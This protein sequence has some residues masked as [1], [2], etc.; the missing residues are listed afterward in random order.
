MGNINDES[1][2]GNLTQVG[3]NKPDERDGLSLGDQSTFGALAGHDDTILESEIEI[4][5]LTSRYTIE[6]PLGKGGMGEVLLANDNRL[7]RKVAIKRVLTEKSRSQIAVSRF[8]TEAQ[9]IASLNHFNIVQVYDYGRDKHGP[10]LIMEYVDGTNLLD[11]CR[12]GAIPLEAAIQITCQLCD[13]LGRAHELGIIHRDIKPANILLTKDGKPK[14]TD[15]GLAKAE[16]TDNGMTIAGA[17]LGTLDFMPPEQRS[18]AALTDARSDLW[19]LAATFYQMVTGKSPRV[20]RLHEFPK[21]LQ[22]VLSKA[23]EDRKEDRYQSAAEFQDALESYTRLAPEAP[24][25]G[26]DL[27]TGEC[28]SCRTKNESHRKF[29]RE[30]AASLRV[31]CLSCK[32]ELPV[33]DKV[34]PE[35]GKKQAELVAARVAAM[36]LERKKA[37]ELYN[38]YAFD[39]AIR[40]VQS[41]GSETDSRLQQLKSWADTFALELTE[42]R[43]RQEDSASKQYADAK[44]HRQ[45]FDYQS[46]IHALESIP[47][48]MRTDEMLQFLV[49]LHEDHET[50]SRLMKEIANRLKRKEMDGL[51]ELIDRAIVLRGEDQELL[52]LKG[53]L[54]KSAASCDDAQQLLNKGKA[55]EALGLIL[56]LEEVYL[57]S[58]QQALKSKLRS[59]VDAELEMTAAVKEANAGG[60]DPDKVVVLL[61]LV[62]AYLQINPHHEKAGSLFQQLIDRVNKT[63]LAYQELFRKLP[64]GVL[65]SIPIESIAK[66]P[67]KVLAQLPSEVLAKLPNQAFAKFPPLM[68]SLGMALNWIPS[69]KFRMGEGEESYDVTIT[70]PYYLGVI[71]VTQEQ[72]QRVMGKNLSSFKGVKNPVENVSWDDAV[73]FCKKLSELPT[74]KSAGRVYRLPTEAEWEYACRAGTTTD[75]SFGD[76]ES[77]LDDYAWYSKNSGQAAHAVG[78][79]EPNAFGL[80]DMH[81]SVWE[82]C[83]DW[84][85]GYP[86]GALID[87]LGPS[88]S[89]YRVCR[90]GSWGSGAAYCRAAYRRTFVPAYRS[91]ICGFRIALSPSVKQP[92]AGQGAQPLD[93]TE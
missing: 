12:E 81:G 39:E 61:P 55:K 80:Y 46:A 92:G 35:C 14:L 83:Q 64:Y 20:I 17:V 50:S 41:I 37:E 19:S 23:L 30:C 49:K 58:G 76:A 38:Q 82:W 90:G 69:G 34:C 7:K 70:R 57:T 6:G 51:Q 68:N 60:I 93:G 2:G 29:C 22:Q 36:K 44:M 31:S 89:T 8:L 78:L 47:E 63:P 3:R 13:G 4:T 71:E 91:P 9:S 87:P 66:Y 86:S 33:W 67:M 32:V 72:Y 21:S 65:D 5:D 1:L 62:T 24:A 53:Q 85:G 18:D 26:A 15:F 16:A 52:E 88:E 25:T 56:D 45:V 28:P 43:I 59:I 75:Y 42:E 73:S 40:T 77:Q 27:G 10:F 11:R 48:P 74:E 79:K 54:T 84:Y